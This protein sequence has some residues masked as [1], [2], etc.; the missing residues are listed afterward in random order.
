MTV[1]WQETASPALAEPALTI[2]TTDADRVTIP[3]SRITRVTSTRSVPIAA[4]KAL[5]SIYEWETIRGPEWE[6][7]IR[8]SVE[9]MR[10]ARAEAGADDVAR[11]LATAMGALSKDGFADAI[12]ERLAG[13]FP[14]FDADGWRVRLDASGRLH[15][16]REVCVAE[17]YEGGLAY[18][19]DDGTA[20]IVTEAARTAEGRRIIDE[21]HR[22][23]PL[24]DRLLD[25]GLLLGGDGQLIYMESYDLGLCPRWDS[26]MFTEELADEEV[27]HIIRYFGKG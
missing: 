19:G 3:L 12:R 24:M 22:E 6:R 26:R 1:T 7:S 27:D 21:S 20:S 15:A 25:E 16:V 23:L 14:A 8:R 2:L 9:G 4:R 5:A 17:H 10:R 18:R 11:T 13:R